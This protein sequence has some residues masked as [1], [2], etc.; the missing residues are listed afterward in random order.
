M[1]GGITSEA[2]GV[3]DNELATSPVLGDFWR[4]NLVTGTWEDV[5]ATLSTDLPEAAYFHSMV[6]TVEGNL[7]VFGGVLDAR[8]IRRTDLVH[9]L[10]VSDARVPSLTY[11]CCERLALDTTKDNEDLE[12]LPKVRIKATRIAGWLITKLVPLQHL[13]EV[14]APFQP[15]TTVLKSV[16][17]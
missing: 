13:H 16:A 1:L 14:I 3:N 12:D 4:L 9:V 5:G 10:R 7:V 11:L 8:S 2:V 17:A 6:C 15:A